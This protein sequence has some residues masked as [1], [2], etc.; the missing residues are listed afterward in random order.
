MVASEAAAREMV[1]DLR[2]EGESENGDSESS[3]LRGDDY[4][5]SLVGGSLNSIIAGAL[6]IA[7]TSHSSCTAHEVSGSVP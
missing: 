4:G 3:T 7:I 6:V 1:A 2:S 5:S